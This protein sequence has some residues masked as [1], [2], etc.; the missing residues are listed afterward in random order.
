M[1]KAFPRELR[2]TWSNGVAQ[3]HLIA[4]CKILHPLEAAICGCDPPFLGSQ[5]LEDRGRHRIHD[6]V[7][8]YLDVVLLGDR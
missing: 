2:R 4:H 1:P 7:L 5:F 6:R 8:V 3:Q